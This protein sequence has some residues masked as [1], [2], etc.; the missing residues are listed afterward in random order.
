MASQQ[1]YIPLATSIVILT[2][3]ITLVLSPTFGIPHNQN[4]ETT[5]TRQAQSLSNTAQWQLLKTKGAPN[6]R[7]E[8]CFVR[9]PDGKGYLLG[10]RDGPKPVDVFDPKTLTWIPKTGPGF[11]IHHMQCVVYKSKI[12]IASSWYGFWPH[13]KSHDKVHV[14]DIG[15]DSWST[16]VGLSEGRRRGAGAFVLYDG[17]MW[18]GMGNR[19]GHGNHSTTLGWLDMFD[20]DANGGLGKWSEVKYPN[21]PNARD[22]VAGG[23]VGGKFCI[24]GGRNGAATNYNFAPVYPVNCFNFAT[25]LWEVGPPIPLGRSG[26]NTAVTC[27]GKLVI[28]G[29]EGNN[30]AYSDMSFFNGVSWEKGPSMKSI[31]HGSGLLVSADCSCKKIYTASGAGGAGVSNL[32]TSTEVF[33][34]QGGATPQCK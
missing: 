25:G 21:A 2:T 13:E 5:S 27:D 32:L 12:W 20:P 9:G 18:L 8:A 34:Y 28:V 31:R 1:F 30:T 26:A 33:L 29:G 10:G 3:I 23:V 15:T 11:E 17:K 6:P 24:A 4:P 19:G 7:V 22:H 14:Y 16:R